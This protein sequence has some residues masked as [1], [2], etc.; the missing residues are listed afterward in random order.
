MT[1]RTHFTHGG[2]DTGEEIG[3]SDRGTHT[4][5]DP[6][7]LGGRVSDVSTDKPE[8]KE[9]NGRNRVKTKVDVQKPVHASRQ[10]RIR[11][12]DRPLEEKLI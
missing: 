3:E 6:S 11:S 4:L 1:S 7:C 9:Y 8:G 5:P 2:A 10:L 12:I